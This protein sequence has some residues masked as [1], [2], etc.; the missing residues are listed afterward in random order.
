MTAILYVLLSIEATAKVAVVVVGVIQ[1]K[2]KCTSFPQVMV[3]IAYRQTQLRSSLRMHGVAAPP[4]FREPISILSIGVYDLCS[5]CRDKY[6]T[7]FKATV[8]S[9]R[10]SATCPR[11]PQSQGEL[12]AQRF[13]RLTPRVRHDQRSSD[14]LHLVSSAYLLR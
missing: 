14:V 5:L 10:D 3:L 13:P 6:L 9:I 2:G 7:G 4:S 12:E 11:C 1:T 8:N